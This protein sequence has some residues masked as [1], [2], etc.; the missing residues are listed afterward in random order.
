MF[1]VDGTDYE[2]VNRILRAFEPYSNL[3]S[4]AKEWIELSR[5]WISGRF[6]DLNAEDVEKN[7]EKF[8][9]TIQKA[10]KFFQKA[11]MN[12]QTS[13]ANE[14]KNQVTHPLTH[15]LTHLLTHSLT[16]SFR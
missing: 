12:L 14:I 15:S 6:V 16:H 4:T 1:D 5:S 2:D 3:W 9:A 7:V 13:I 8:S 10:V 11:E